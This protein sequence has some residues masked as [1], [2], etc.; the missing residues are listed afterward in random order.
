MKGAGQ[1]HSGRMRGKYLVIGV[2]LVGLALLVVGLVRLERGRARPEVVRIVE[3]ARE[4]FEISASREEL[5][6]AARRAEVR[7]RCAGDEFERLVLISSARGEKREEWR[8]LFV[9]GV[10]LGVALPGHYP[11]EFGARREDYARW[12]RQMGEAGINAVRAYTVLPPEFYEAL[13]EHNFRTSERPV[14]LVQ[15]IWAELPES[16][17]FHEPGYTRALQQGIRDA[18]DVVAGRAVL[19]ERPGHASGVYT[20]DVSDFTLGYLFGREWEPDVVGTTDSTHR[21]A[22]RY[23]GVFLNVPAGSPTEAWL[24]GMLDH[25]VQY[26]VLAYGVQRPVAFVSWL[27]LDPMFHPSE[28][29][30]RWR[31]READND[32]VALHPLALQTTP[33][34]RAGYYAAYHVYPYYPDFVFLDSAYVAHRDARG[35]PDCYA[36]YLADL[37]R[38]HPGLP[39]LVAEFGVPSSRGNSHSSRTGMNHGGHDEREQA[40]MNLAML[41]DIHDEGLAGGVVFA[42]LD[43]WFKRNW[44]LNDF[45][46][47]ADR[48]RLWHNV[49]NPEQCFGMVGFG[50]RLLAVDGDAADW[51]GKPLSRAAAGVRALWAA[52]DEEYCYLRIDLAQE[53]DWT[54]ETVGLAIDTYD[55]RLGNRRLGRFNRDCANGVEFLVV[56]SDTGD[57]EVLVDSGYSLYFDPYLSGRPAWRTAPGDDGAFVTQRLVNNHLRLTA[58]AETIPT[59]TTDYGRLSFG[60]S[61]DN[62]LADWFARGR[63]IELRLPWALLNVTDPSSFQVLQ[64]DPQTDSVESATTGGFC[65]SA[66]IAG[67]DPAAGFAATLPPER[68]GVL[69]FTRRWRWRGW[70]EPQY[71]EHLK[72]SYR[73]FAAGLPAV[74]RDSGPRRAR[75]DQLAGARGTGERPVTA[76]IARFRSDRAGAVSFTFDGGA[77]DQ[78]TRAAPILGRYGFKAGFGLVPGWTGE[79]ADWHADANGTPFLRLSVA[80]ARGL[81]D[82]GHAIALDARGAAGGVAAGAAELEQALEVPVRT[83]HCPDSAAG[84]ALTSGMR[85]AG[86]WFGRVL[87]GGYNLSDRFD[88]FRISSFVVQGE[89]RPGLGEFIGLLDAGRGRWTVLAYRHVLEADARELQTMERHGV[90]STFSVTPLT[91]ARHARLVRNTGAWVAPVEDVG[92]YLLQLRQARLELRQ[93]GQSAI[94]AIGGVRPGGLPPVPMTVVCEVPWNWVTVSGSVNDGTW[95][96][97][98]GRLT[99]DILPGQEVIL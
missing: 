68:G 86:F 78:L 83:C 34:L 82:Q 66:F 43:E 8:R 63:V 80:D 6:A 73:L 24:A 11:T 19:P 64:D 3:P 89:D 28:Y 88:P 97:Y 13:A 54:R 20:A 4:P 67:K 10:N 26:E 37:K 57:A 75:L 85:A 14:F 53:P 9:V 69:Q 84:P 96:P 35:E 62:S 1:G 22:R 16:G 65:F 46:V 59:R 27:P 49:Q 42:W 25:L 15:G 99:L 38:H 58:A 29:T 52:A 94:L 50:R 91:F 48:V 45:A 17:D 5:V 77:R 56:L 2:L 44:L 40:A 51:S 55:Q 79:Q 23:E 32:L 47:P 74:L 33:A 31:A 72:Q 60:R 81:L 71:D 93:S 90:T 12:L 70:E 87:G 18:V 98:D 76:R 41:R 92:R 61:D 39:L 7:F 21:S 95:S 30:D 36:G